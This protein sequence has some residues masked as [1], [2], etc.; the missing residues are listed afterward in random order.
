MSGSLSRRVLKG[1]AEDLCRQCLAVWLVLAL[2]IQ[3]GV[4]QTA[5]GDWKNVQDLPLGSTIYVTTKSGEKYH[6]V[7][8][9]V[10]SATLTNE[11]RRTRIPRA[12]V[13]EKRPA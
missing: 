13:D 4:A 11:L 6:G 12:S 8:V 9:N 1:A 10:T 5:L 2:A 7:L 3:T